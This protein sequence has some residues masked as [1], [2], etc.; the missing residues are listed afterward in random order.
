VRGECLP[1]SLVDKNGV[2]Q[3]HL[4]V[5]ERRLLELSSDAAVPLQAQQETCQEGTSPTYRERRK[6]NLC[7]TYHPCNLMGGKGPSWVSMPLVKRPT[8]IKT[9]TREHA[10]SER[11]HSLRTNMF[12]P[13]DED[14]QWPGSP[15]RSRTTLRNRGV[16]CETN[17]CFNGGTCLVKEF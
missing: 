5:R 14:H 13:S 3:Y 1:S 10:I 6:A 17:T 16:D 9:V 11:R 15:Q 4:K 12:V 8:V 2:E 7:D